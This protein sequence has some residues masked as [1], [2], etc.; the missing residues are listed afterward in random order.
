[1]AVDNS[2]S[3]G[4]RA[5][6]DTPGSGA[7]TTNLGRR[8]DHEEGAA[9]GTLGDVE[10]W[11][12]ES[13]DENIEVGVVAPAD[14]NKPIQISPDAIVR[15]REQVQ[16]LTQ[17]QRDIFLREMPDGEL[18]KYASALDMVIVDKIK[19]SKTLRVQKWIEPLVE[20]VNICK[21]LADSLQEVY[22]PAGLILGGIFFIMS[23][24]KKAVEYQEAVVRFLTTI[25]KN[26]RVME[27]CKDIFPSTPELQ[28]ALIDV[29]GDILKFCA[30]A[31]APFI[32][33]KGKPKSSISLLLRSQIKTFENEFGELSKSLTMHL[34]VF[35]RA[36]A[37]VSGQM[38]IQLQQTQFVGAK[39]QAKAYNEFHVA[40]KRRVVDEQKR[41]TRALMKEQDE[42]RGQLLRWISSISFQDTQ[43]EKLDRGLEGT[44]RWL[45]DSDEFVSWKQHVS[46]DLLW[47]YGKHG[48]GKSHLAAQ[49]IKILEVLC[50]ERNGSRPENAVG[51]EG[52]AIVSDRKK[53]VAAPSEEAHAGKAITHD[54]E[55][56]API[57]LS[58]SKRVRTGLD[59][60]GTAEIALKPLENSS[61]T[62][63]T[64]LAYVYCSALATSTHDSVSSSQR[65]HNSIENLVNNVLGSIL[66]QLYA[67][68]P[69]E[70]DVPSLRELCFDIK[71]DRPG[72]QDIRDGIKAIIPAFKQT[73][74]VV[75][76]LDE[77]N[78][79]KEVEFESL[80]NF[81][82]S[83]GSINSTGPS[84]NVAIFSRPGYWAIEDALAGHACIQVDGGANQGDITR[85]IRD[86]TLHLTRDQSILDDIQRTLLDDAEG[87]FLWVSLVID[88]LKDKRSANKMKTA[89]K[90]M[91]RGLHG[92]Y[93]VALLRI[94]SQSESVRDLAL[95][96]LLWTV[97][98]LEPLTNEE[99]LEALAIEPEMDEITAG[100]RLTE[101]VPLTTDC[102]DLLVFRGGRFQPLHPS[103][104]EF[105]HGLGKSIIDDGLLEYRHLQGR[106]HYLLAETCLTYLNMKVFKDQH[107][108]PG[109]TID[110]IMKHYPFLKYAA[111]NWGSHLRDCN[112]TGEDFN[113]IGE[114]VREL[115]SNSRTRGFAYG[116]LQQAQHN[117]GTESLH[118]DATPLHFLAI[119]GLD[120]FLPLFDNVESDIH[121]P[122]GRGYFPIYYALI[123]KQ[124]SMSLWI[125]NRCRR[126]QA[127]KSR[128][129]LSRGNALLL[130]AAWHNWP[131]VLR[132]LLELGLTENAH[133]TGGLVALCEA[134]KL[135]YTEIIE[136][137]L[138]A[139]VDPNARDKDG[140][141]AVML[142][143]QS[144]HAAAARRLMQA[145]AD[146]S[147]TNDQGATALHLVCE[148]GDALLTEELLDRG[149]NINRKWLDKTS[150]EIA[151]KNDHLRIIRL[152]CVRGANSDSRSQAIIWSS[153][154]GNLD[155]V[156]VLL[157]HGVDITTKD[158][159]GQT[160]LHVSARHSSTDIMTLLLQNG[161][162][163][164]I[165]MTDRVG[166]S[167]LHYAAS[168][169][170]VPCVQL[171]VNNHAKI[172]CEDSLRYS[173]AGYSPLHLAVKEGHWEVSKILIE[174]YGANAS[175]KGRNGKTCMHFAALLTSTSDWVGLLAKSMVDPNPPDDDG[176]TPM[177][178][179]A[180]EGNEAFARALFERI[181]REVDYGQQG[182]LLLA[183]KNGH[184]NMLR[185][186]T[187]WYAQ[188]PKSTTFLGESPLHESA[189][190]GNLECMKV[191]VEVYPQFINSKNSSH[192]TPLYLACRSSSIDV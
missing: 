43:D 57:P 180:E 191:L 147:L 90:T 53:A 155:A 34:E 67:Y 182:C 1:M 174:N 28:L 189:R 13:D 15:W 81:L 162:R 116:I 156:K 100:D 140:N 138:Q 169:G 14:G 188:D 176:I 82:A 30:K 70:Q 166:Y 184:A 73:F 71:A 94:C 59:E 133:S 20:I 137:L 92:A 151:A 55:D 86:R 177:H 144:Q 148:Y 167:P 121:S 131:D 75:D 141:T 170:S 173:M 38:L 3:A 9:S 118:L 25:L 31:S 93:S 97:N 128:T 132:K 21:P 24:S 124:R 187:A 183:A 113:H 117:Y 47:V 179:A 17:D 149:A 36:V 69:R 153:G 127:D 154:C 23:M 165:E 49:V 41:D 146:I 142:A 103:L 16:A 26:L 5:A 161:G 101:S 159:I 96:A 58:S 44:G 190:N 125:L 175:Q 157:Q 108:R 37:L 61:E 105:L 91:P 27:K 152:L 111:R 130:A 45:I 77:C 35:D 145:G 143:A 76:G 171:L 18:Q 102:A 112:P 83:L 126:E 80:C 168:T 134:A 51:V 122:D 123:Y 119:Y 106:S 79:L 129:S 178:E 115:L 107:E 11:E 150:L 104:V 114:M 74:I 135:G 48:S 99:L 62:K 10:V 158:M 29:Y 46:G 19:T 56:D 192:K 98:A 33:N 7:L 85:F 164:C 136:V 2:I 22:P 42:R 172:H 54:T 139:G 95:R 60:G 109:L 63:K 87:M 52:H 181:P 12:P 89:L 110:A 50:R 88:S 84:A 65:P 66:K 32:D 78:P 186:F 6:A 163:E 185:A 4:K 64:A 72:R 8:S 160:A 39:V 68:L 120:R 40:E